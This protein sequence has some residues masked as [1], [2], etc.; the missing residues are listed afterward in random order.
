[1][2]V[3][4]SSPLRGL[5]AAAVLLLALAACRGDAGTP[6]GVESAGPA[7]AGTVTLVNFDAA[8]R[9]LTR[10]DTR[11][12]QVDAH[13]GEIR[14]FEGRYYLYAETYGCGFEWHKLAP[15]PFCGFRVYS[16][17]NLVEWTDQGL[18]FDVSGWEPWQRRCNWWTH[19]CFRPHVLY[20]RATR[21]YVLWVNV[22][23]DPVN[24]YV[25][26]SSS[27]TGPFVE[28]ALPRLAFNN[29][30]RQGA[31][32]NGDENL[33]VDDDGTGYIIYTEWA[34][35]R[36]DLVVERLTPDYL[37]GTGQ[38]VRLGV[39]QNES[40]TLFKRNGRYYVT[41][42]APPNAAY[43]TSRTSYYSAPSPLGPWSGPRSL[44][45]TSCGGQPGHVSELPTPDGGS[46]YLYQSDLWI[47]SDGKG[48]G[49]LNQAPAPQ[50]WAPLSFDRSGEIG[51]I[52]CGRSYSVP[53]LV[54]TPPAREPD[55]RRLQCDVGAAGGRGLMREFRFVAERGGRARSVAVN[56]Y[57]RGE[58]DSP[59]VVELRD[60]GA[61]GAALHTTTVEPDGA[62]WDVPVN[63]AWSARRE[64]LPLDA[65]VEAGREYAVR[66]RSAATRGCYGY[67]FRG[68]AA[69]GAAS[70]WVSTD[71]GAS[72]TRETGQAVEV[73][74]EV[75]PAAAGS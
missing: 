66:L 7:P 47:N 53:A 13:G 43:G 65:A 51:P 42:S 20:N 25:L 62:A 2:P 34:I 27:P 11:G 28:R 1:M 40:P 45:L 44:N 67:A 9:A 22:Y 19:G 72:W 32:N 29:D 30:A 36:G 59:L 70:S 56:T 35:G 24:Y 50:F 10:F 46:W 37:S 31:V 39:R 16:S 63:I 74:V 60:V 3:R 15:S 38:R 69:A 26:E 52:T 61:G 75:E 33:F 71:G 54:V 18:L 14:W 5:P 48:S 64:V 8:G 6:L 41:A 58:P 57:Q 23:D 73:A 12:S 4:P 49:D 21:K 68:G 55:A 17:P